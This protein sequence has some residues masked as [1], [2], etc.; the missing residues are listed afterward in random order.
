MRFEHIKN[1]FKLRILKKIMNIEKFT[2][3]SQEVISKAQHIALGKQ[4]QQIEN[5]H[6][7]KAIFEEDKDIVP[8]LLKK[9]NINT[10]ILIQAVDKMVDS[11]PIVSGERYLLLN[12][13][14]L[15]LQ[16]RLEAENQNPKDDYVSIEH[17]L[18][19]ILQSNDNSSQLLKDSGLTEKGLKKAIME[20]RKGSRVDSPHAEESYNALNRYALNLNDLARKD[21]LDPVIGREE[22]I[23]RVLQILLLRTKKQSYFNR[24]SR[25]RK[26]GYCR[27]F[28]SSN[29]FGGYS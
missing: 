2:I 4:Q 10:A 12:A 9:N 18:L 3:K 24:R 16:K 1:S 27:R 22:E 29:C 20:L 15:S 13:A 11:L 19:G 21:K 26:N 17:L 25:N 14:N 23:R 6:L 28:S 7:L 5:A 8:Y